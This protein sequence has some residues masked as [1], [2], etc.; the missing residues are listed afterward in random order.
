MGRLLL[1]DVV[2]SVAILV[3]WYI[4]FSHYNRKK[5]RPPCAGCKPPAPA[6]DESWNRVGWEHR[7][8]RLA[9]TSLLGGLRMPA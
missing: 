3:L 2:S 7:A 1:I 4:V 5:A 9:F 6:R 8:C